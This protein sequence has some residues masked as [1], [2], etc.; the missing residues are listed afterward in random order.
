MFKRIPDPAACD[1]YIYMRCIESATTTDRLSAHGHQLNAVLAQ[2]VC[3]RRSAPT[4]AVSLCIARVRMAHG[5][6]A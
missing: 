2:V 3:H 1:I 6:S 4:L 5:M